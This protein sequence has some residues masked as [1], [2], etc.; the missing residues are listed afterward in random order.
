MLDTK[1]VLQMVKFKYVGVVF[2]SDGRWSGGDWGL[3]GEA[4]WSIMFQLSPIV[5]G[6]N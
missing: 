6:H 1:S 3:K 4:L 2:I 5:M